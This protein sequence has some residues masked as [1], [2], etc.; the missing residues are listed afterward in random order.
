MLLTE[1]DPDPSVQ[2]IH[3]GKEAHSSMQK[4]S[5]ESKSSAFCAEL[6]PPCG[7]STVQTRAVSVCAWAKAQQS[8]SRDLKPNCTEQ[9]SQRI[10]IVFVVGSGAM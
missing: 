8:W 2:S 7:P 9:I 10:C 4:P 6:C 5:P 3:E 1:Y